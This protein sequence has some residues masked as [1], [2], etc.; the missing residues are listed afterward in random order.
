[1]IAQ[2]S[3]SHLDAL[4]SQRARQVSPR[5]LLQGM[6]DAG[7]RISFVFGF[8]DP[9]SLPADEVS[10]AT[11][12]ALA[13]RGRAALQY[14]DNAGYSG[15]IDALREKLARDQGIVAERENILVTAG[16]SQAI[17]LLLDALVDWGDTIASEMPTWLGAVQA[18]HNVGANV[19]SI[20][21]NEEG[22]DVVTLER[23]LAHLR[24]QGITPKFVYAI[25]NFQ[26]PTG[27]TMSLQRR[28]DLLDIVRAA[29]TLLIED[30]AYFDLR[31]DGENLPAIYTLDDSQSVVYM[32][33]LSKTMG[34]G[35]RLGWLVGPPALISRL[36]ALKVD[37]GTNVFGAHV[38]AEWLPEKLLPHVDRLRAVY[39]RR[40]DLMLAALERHMPPGVT[41]TVP[42]GGFFIWVTFPEGIDTAA[43]HPQVNE[44]GAEYL[45]GPTCFADGS[46]PNQL[47]LS[48]SFAQDEEI[49]D[50]IRIIADV[51]RAELREQAR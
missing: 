26:N 47:R 41:W 38:A 20:P 23:E 21:V 14:G 51:A 13:E 50:G 46:G 16:G 28:Q 32:G 22:T 34:P 7:K 4:L 8:P 10:I 45:P 30:D 29:G 3:S 39:R 15:L 31:Y 43:M 37:G 36:T 12:K 48:F 40:R 5:P 9:A 6:D 17:G 19:V 35:M 18:F 2:T 27:V 44:L 25:P 11:E 1:M 42:D 33:T 24:S 49:D